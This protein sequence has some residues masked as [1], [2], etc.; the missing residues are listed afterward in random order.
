[1]IILIYQL[2]SGSLGSKQLPPAS[3]NEP[4]HRK[5]NNLPRRKQ[6]RRSASAKLISAFVFATRKVQFLF[7]FNLKFQASSCHLWLYSPVCVGPVRKPHSWF[8]H[9]TAQMLKHE[10]VCLIPIFATKSKLQIYT[11][12]IGVKFVC[13]FELML[14]VLVNG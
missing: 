7:F 8:S 3:A 2:L 4:P 14:N 5:T 1:M 11:F 6:R 9:E 13:L 10:K 12:T